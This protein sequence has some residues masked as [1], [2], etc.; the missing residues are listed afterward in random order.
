MTKGI[1]VYK[2]IPLAKLAMT[3]DEVEVFVAALNAA[4]EGRYAEALITND[5]T[6]A[7]DARL[8]RRHNL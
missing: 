6:L 3:R 2:H 8:A 5:N 1:L 7:I 4:S